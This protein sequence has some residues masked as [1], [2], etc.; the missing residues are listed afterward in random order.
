MLNKILSNYNIDVYG[1]TNITDFSYLKNI[2]NS[3]LAD[4]HIVEFDEKDF[5]KR[6]N[7]N[8]IF[9]NIKSIISIAFPYNNGN[10][11]EY[12]EYKI[13]KYALRLDYHHVANNI[14]EKIII[15]LKNIYP[16]NKFEIYVDSNPLFEKE[17]AKNSGIGL[18]GKNSLI[19]TKKYGSF[20]FLGEILTDLELAPTELSEEF[21][22]LCNKCNLCKTSCPNSAILGDFKLEATKCIAYLTTTKNNISPE[23]IYNNYWGCDICQDVCPMNKNI[24]SSPIKEFKILNNLYISIEKIL[25][26]S[27]KKLKKFYSNTPI[28]WTGAN[29]LKRNALIIIGNSNNKKYIDLLEKFIKSNNNEILLKYAKISLEKLNRTI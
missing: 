21:N 15:E 10:I 6:S 20:I 9:P 4:N 25:F 5:N 19:Y 26:M 28:G 13:S 11:P 14:L 23:L 24:S 27:N 17:I 16:N 3:K 7:L 18:Y 1:I 2:F 22:L 12:K 8:N 29:T